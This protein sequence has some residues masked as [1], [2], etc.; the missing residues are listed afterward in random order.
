MSSILNYFYLVFLFWMA[1]Y[2]L[3]LQTISSAEKSTSTVQICW[4]MSSLLGIQPRNSH[5]RGNLCWKLPNL[6]YLGSQTCNQVEGSQLVP[7]WKNG[8]EIKQRETHMYQQT[9][10]SGC[11][12]TP[13]CLPGASEFLCGASRSHIYWLH[14]TIFRAYQKMIAFCCLQ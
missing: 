1:P 10:C 9:M 7:L 12:K 6:G 14:T 13:V 3:F 11:N 2:T 5:F 8:P 4:E